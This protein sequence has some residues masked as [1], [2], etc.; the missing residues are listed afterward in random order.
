MTTVVPHY[1]DL[2]IS[3][4]IGGHAKVLKSKVL[5][6]ATAQLS[7]KTMGGGSDASQNMYPP[8]WYSGGCPTHHQRGHLVGNT[9]GGT[10]DSCDNLVT[11]TAG[12]NH[13]FMYALEGKIKRYVEDNPG[14]FMYEITCHYDGYTL[15]KIAEG[16]V[17]P[18]AVGNPLCLFP[19]PSGLTLR[20]RPFTL[21]GPPAWIS[22]GE[23]CSK[24][25]DPVD[26]LGPSA[27]ASTSWH[28]PNGG[29]KLNSG[30]YH[31]GYCSANSVFEPLTNAKQSTEFVVYA[32]H[33]G[34]V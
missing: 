7:K 34:Y 33:L 27:S 15:V 14:Q 11:L 20:L 26:E 29:Y 13:P 8:G 17:V 19:S 21:Q 6:S 32:K 10:G 30:D 9:L 31:N 28:I 3:Y 22:L 24:Y 18:C 4:Q 5:T 23:I 16:F 2:S 25:T 1:D 12:T